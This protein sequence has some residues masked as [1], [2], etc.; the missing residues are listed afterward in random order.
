MASTPT[1]ARSGN[2]QSTQQNQAKRVVPIPFC[3]AARRKSIQAFDQTFTL[4]AGSVTQ[5]APILLAPAGY[6]ADLD[7]RVQITSTGNTATVAAPAV[8]DLPWNVVN[9]I[10]VTNA[11]GDSLYVGIPGYQLYLIN[12]Y[13]GIYQPPFCDP[14]ADQVYTALTTGAGATA[15]SGS[16]MLRLPFQID[17]RDAFC[18][19][20]NLAANKAYQLVINLASISQIWAGGTAPNGAVSVQVTIVMNYW[21]QPNPA[22]G[23]GFPRRLRLAVLVR[24]RFGAIRRSMSLVVAPARISLLT[25]ATSSVG[26]VSLCMTVRRRR[27]DPTASGRQSTIFG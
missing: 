19:L 4:S 14:R 23:D 18:A 5:I 25:L 16:F 26:L 22:N 11:A 2:P 7:V 24:C 17:P 8:G 21:G 9:S 27:C 1:V 10:Q 13:S 12:K 6:L 15:G 20:P 3:R